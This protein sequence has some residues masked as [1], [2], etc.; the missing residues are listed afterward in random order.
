MRTST[1]LERT[2]NLPDGRDCIVRCRYTAG[3]KAP[4]ASNHDSPAFSD[5]GDGAELEILST[6]VEQSDGSYRTP[7]I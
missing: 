7:S 5:P 6:R 1:E 3:R 4:Y 2:I